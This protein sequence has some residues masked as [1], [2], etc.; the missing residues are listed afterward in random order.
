MLCRKFESSREKAGLEERN[1]SARVRGILA[2]VH[3]HESMAFG[4]TKNKVLAQ[5]DF[6]NRQGATAFAEIGLA[7]TKGKYG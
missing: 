1:W 3:T 4:T 6:R 5:T 2:I 7:K